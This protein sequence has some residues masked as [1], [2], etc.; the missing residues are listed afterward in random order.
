MKGLSAVLLQIA[1]SDDFV[2]V[3]MLAFQTNLIVSPTDALVANGMKRRTPCMGATITVW[4]AP[5]PLDPL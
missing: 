5:E 4:V 3:C 2:T 1:S